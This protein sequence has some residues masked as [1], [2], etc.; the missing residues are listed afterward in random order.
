M[1]GY[2]ISTILA[3]VVA[4]PQPICKVK[5]GPEPVGCDIRL[6]INQ[7][8][9]VDGKW[10]D[11]TRWL[12]A[13]AWYRVAK[14]LLDAKWCKKGYHIILTARTTERV[15]AGKNGDPVKTL[16]Y[17]ILDAQPVLVSGDYK[18]QQRGREDAKMERE[19]APQQDNRYTDPYARPHA[20]ASTPNAGQSYTPLNEESEDIPF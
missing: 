11:Y 4:D 10:V 18:S 13:T 15:Y 12:K 6:A 8:N 3:T 7:S 20:L 9:F 16:D 5:S 14:R 1:N 17:E 19:R 2:Q